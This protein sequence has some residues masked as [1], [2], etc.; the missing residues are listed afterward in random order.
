MPPEWTLYARSEQDYRTDIAVYAV[1]TLSSWSC[2]SDGGHDYNTA[3]S[4]L[5][6]WFVPLERIV[7]QKL[8]S[9]TPTL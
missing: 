8:A 3:F 9:V 6:A 4:T 2:A 5:H 7:Q 1:L